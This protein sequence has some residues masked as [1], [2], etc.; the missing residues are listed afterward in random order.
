ME[1]SNWRRYFLIAPL[2]VLCRDKPS[3]CH[4]RTE[5]KGLYCL[6]SLAV[7]V[8][9]GICTMWV[10]VSMLSTVGSSAVS[11]CCFLLVCQ[12]EGLG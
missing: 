4:L 3:V 6:E 2:S 7:S 10:E 9:Y 5:R 1:Q 11:C 12:T 8:K